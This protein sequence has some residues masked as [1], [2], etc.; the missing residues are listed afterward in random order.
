MILFF[1]SG[2]CFRLKYFVFK[3]ILTTRNFVLMMKM[4]FDKDFV[5]YQFRILFFR[6]PSFVIIELNYR[7]I[8]MSTSLL[9]STYPT[10]KHVMVAC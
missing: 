7:S 9:E 10:Y 4:V 6:S 5:D 8:D 2:C 3:S 1:R